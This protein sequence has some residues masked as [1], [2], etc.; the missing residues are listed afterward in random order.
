MCLKQLC[1][2]ST[3]CGWDWGREERICG[4]LQRLCLGPAVPH[5]NTPFAFANIFILVLGFAGAWLKMSGFDGGPTLERQTG[6]REV[7]IGYAGVL[8]A[9]TT[10]DLHFQAIWMLVGDAR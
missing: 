9:C 4:S 5:Y 2:D 7:F 10:S 6:H 8:Y 1:G 3:G